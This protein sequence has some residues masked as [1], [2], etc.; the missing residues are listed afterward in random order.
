MKK[1]F[2]LRRPAARVLATL[3]TSLG[4]MAATV[5]AEA[6]IY[7]G[8][9]D[10]AF[11]GRFTGLGW[12]GE[13]VFQVPNE[14]L[15]L[16]T[17]SMAE[18]SECAGSS[19][20]SASVTLYNL[21]NPSQVDVLNFF[22]PEIKLSIYDISI[23][24]GAVTGI[25]TLMLKSLGGIPVAIGDGL[26]P[27]GTLGSPV[28]DWYDQYLY[29][30]HIDGGTASLSAGSTSIDYGF[31]DPVDRL[32]G[33]CPSLF[34]EAVVCFSETRPTVTYTALPP[35]QVPEPASLA[36]VGLALAGAAAARQRRGVR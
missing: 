12:K 13:V 27:A 34:G 15:A 35:S 5:P 29:G 8:S 11:G 9:F 31:G 23:A 25:S 26:A 14:C 33:K 3:A 19:V 17:A 20:E 1:C 21:G 32:P 16:G 22:G 6:A 30:L 36:L 10:P 4:L 18:N 28:V 24:G 7:V 2:S